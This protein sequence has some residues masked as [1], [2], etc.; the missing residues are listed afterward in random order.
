MNRYFGIIGYMTT[1]EDPNYPSVYMPVLHEQP[2][3]GDIIKDTRR[4]ETND[5]VNDH[6]KL[7]VRISIIADENIIQNASEIKYAEYLGTKWCV[8]DIEPAHPR[9]I[10]TLGEIYTGESEVR[11]KDAE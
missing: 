2:Y 6:L 5:T 8:T 9:L 10:L 4:R 11:Q 3:F 1:E 7:A